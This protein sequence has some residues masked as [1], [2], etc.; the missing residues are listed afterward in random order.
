MFQAET[1]RGNAARVRRMRNAI[2]GTVV[3][4][5]ITDDEGARKKAL[6]NRQ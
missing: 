3:S 5:A 4:Y 6:D 2:R 1:G